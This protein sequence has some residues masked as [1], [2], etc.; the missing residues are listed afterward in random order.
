MIHEPFQKSESFNERVLTTT[1]FTLVRLYFL[2]CPHL[3]PTRLRSANSHGGRVP[4]H[5]H[6]QQWK[7][8]LV[9]IFY[10][11]KL[12]LGLS[13]APEI[14]PVF[15]FSAFVLVQRFFFL[16]LG[17]GLLS[18]L[19]HQVELEEKNMIILTLR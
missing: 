10:L 6:E 17:D 7:S 2:H 15:L 19:P 5:Q 13:F 14:C 11:P 3:H 8:P 4:H 9:L 18:L 16:N 1:P 12:Q